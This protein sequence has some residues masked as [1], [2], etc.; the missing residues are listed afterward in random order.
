MAYK[1]KLYL[2]NPNK[3]EKMIETY[4][5]KR[6]N[7]KRLAD[8]KSIERGVRE[9]LARKISGTLIGIWLLIPEHLR[10]GTWD[11]LKSWTGDSTDGLEPRLSLQMVHEAALCVTGVRE[12]RSLNHQG[13]EI[14]NGLPF[15]A[16]DQ[17]IH[18]L[19]DA[20]S[21][22]DAKKLQ[23]ELALLRKSLGH[24]NAELI[25]FDPHRI[26][27]YSRRI[28]PQ[29]KANPEEPSRPVLQT[30]F[31]L[32]AETGQ[33]M[34]FTMGSSGKTATKASIELLEMMD[35]VLILEK[36]IQLL[37]DTEHES[38][39]L[40]DYI[41]ESEKYDILMPG[42]YKNKLISII[43]NLTYQ[44]HWA[45]Y[46]TAETFYRYENSQHD[47]RLIGQRNGES[48]YQYKPFIATGN[49]SSLEL[50]T[51]K[52]PERWTIE[53]FFNFEGAMG[54]DRA[55]TMNLNI[56]YGKL[57]LALIAQAAAYQF[58]KKLPKPYKQWTAKHL[59]DSIFRGI[60]GDLRV[61]DDTIIV[62]LYNVP[63]SLNL[64]KYYENLPKKLES[65]G[66]NPEIPWLF[67]Y[68]VDFCF[69]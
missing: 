41:I 14:A 3:A 35:L 53:E 39:V 7:K 9:L 27:T 33:P 55:A 10:L 40:L 32:D 60:D 22:E 12:S 45:G 47:F 62:T 20:H 58:K 63:D 1:K 42:S 43:Q 8:F 21:M 36:N 44:R 65:E 16:A 28:M 69:K 67:N 25:A 31:S 49:S 66:V 37:A 13:F 59:A 52:F 29:K 5:T 64:K 30:F 38:Q 57:S 2:F 17:E 68:K 18:E 15:I 23:I 19:L 4:H 11:L 24:Y 54:W 48:E 51:E 46:A 56:R 6:Q 50:I 34:F 26:R 61:K